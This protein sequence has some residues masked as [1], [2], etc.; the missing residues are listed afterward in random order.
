MRRDTHIINIAVITSIWI[1]LSS[2]CTAL[3]ASAEKE[4]VF[5]EK[6]NIQEGL[7]VHVDPFAAFEGLKGADLWAVSALTR[8]KLSEIQ[9]LPSPPV[10]DGLIAAHGCLYISTVDGSMHC[11]GE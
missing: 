5:I 11:F 3:S 8:E 4:R 2:F 9:H 1:V 7:V 6:S 10:Y